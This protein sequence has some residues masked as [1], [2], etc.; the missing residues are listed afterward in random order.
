VKQN[1]AGYGQGEGSD[2]NKAEVKTKKQK[3]KEK[4]KGKKIKQSA[5]LSGSGDCEYGKKCVKKDCKD[6]HPPGHTVEI[7]IKN[8]TAETGGPCTKCKSI[9]HTAEGCTKER[10]CFNCNQTGHMKKDCKSVQQNVAKAASERVRDVVITPKKKQV[11]QNAGS[12][13]MDGCKPPIYQFRT[14]ISMG[15]PVPSVKFDTDDSEVEEDD[16]PVL[17]SS[18]SDEG[19]EL[20]T[21]GNMVER[22]AK[23]RDERRSKTTG[24][25]VRYLLK[26]REKKEISMNALDIT[27]GA[28]SV[29]VNNGK[30]YIDSGAQGNSHNPDFTLTGIPN[31]GS[32][33]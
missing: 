7:G 20:E 11:G 14:T 1:N 19:E 5:A 27:N 22:L 23:E 30:F 4:L 24:D 6:K 13:S 12:L 3:H 26:L 8:I 2:S 29:K 21:V 28:Q 15:S 18:S 9:F 16:I 17:Y 10:K 33:L 25:A 31:F 32:M